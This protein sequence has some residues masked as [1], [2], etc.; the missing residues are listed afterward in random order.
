[1][2]Q[3]RHTDRS[4]IVR[5]LSV[6]PWV[7]LASISVLL[8]TELATSGTG[9]TRLLFLIVMVV[10]WL[11]GAVILTSPE[12]PLKNWAVKLIVSLSFSAI[13]CYTAIILTR[14]AQFLGVSPVFCSGPFVALPMAWYLFFLVHMSP[15]RCPACER[16]SLLPLLRLASDDKRSANTRWCAGCGGKYWKDRTGT[17]QKERRETW[18]DREETPAAPTPAAGPAIAA[19]VSKLNKAGSQAS[20][21]TKV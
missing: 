5:R 20:P 21:S 8:T 3:N 6:V 14:M 17:W 10:P 19:P 18:H 4:L 7:Y 2:K 12:G 13:L 15:R 16:R 11:A 1:M 9:I